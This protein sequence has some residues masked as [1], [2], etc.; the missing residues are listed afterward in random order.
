[1]KL[2]TVQKAFL[3]LIVIALVLVFTATALVIYRTTSGKNVQSSYPNGTEVPVS[4]NE[5]DKTVRTSFP[6]TEEPNSKA[7]QVSALTNLPALYSH[8]SWTLVSDNQAS[9]G[10]EALYYSSKENKLVARPHD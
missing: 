5:L 4:N 6:A 3:A 2:T 1:M 10:R 7:F 9:L 8:L